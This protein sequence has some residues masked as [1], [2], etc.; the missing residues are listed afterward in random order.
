MTDNATTDQ[1]E[2]PD[3]AALVAAQDWESVDSILEGMADPDVAKVLPTLERTHWTALLNRLPPERA[4]S[5]YA[6]LSTEQQTQLLDDLSDDEKAEIIGQLSYDDAAA[7]L[8]ELPDEHTELLMDMLPREDQ[9]VLQTLLSYPE[10]SA[11]RLMTPQFVALRPEWDVRQCLDHVRRQAEE[12]ETLS[13]LFVT[14]DNGQIVGWVRLQDLLLGRPSATLDT[15]MQ[16]DVISIPADEDQEEAARLIR[17]YD[18]EVLPVVDSV[19]RIAG[20]ITVDDIMDVVE[21]ETTEDFQKMGSVGVL[22]LSIKEATTTLLY[23]KRIGWLIILVFVNMF[24]GAAIGIFE[25]AIE[26]VVALVFF[27]PMIIAS[28]G[29]AGAQ[30]STLMVRALA[31]GDVQVRDWLKLWGKEMLVA[32]SLGLTMGLA[33]WA[34]GVWLGGPQVG[35]AVAISMVLVVVIGSMIGMLL[36]FMLARFRLDPATASAPLITSVVDIAGILMYFSVA[37][38]ILQLSM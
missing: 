22:N 12:G 23:R 20:I 21:E 9:E 33:V 1:A 4:A 30:A 13:S 7:L 11:G 17:H 26:Q 27:L 8:E 36:P 31:T 29:N 5:V 25:A 35:L 37:T 2:T 38:L 34:A 14:S 28:G 3:I 15:L 32:F 16:P 10:D 6:Y 18:L 19:G 24:A